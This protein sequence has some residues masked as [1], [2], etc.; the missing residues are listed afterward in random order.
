[1]NIVIIIFIIRVSIVESLI[2]YNIIRKG[3]AKTRLNII[4]V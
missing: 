3:T 4:L 2:N 1:M